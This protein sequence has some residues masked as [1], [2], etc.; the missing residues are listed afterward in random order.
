MGRRYNEDAVQKDIKLVPYKIIKSKNGDSWVVEVNSK[1][2]S[3]QEVSEQVLI[4]LK[5]DAE[6]YLGKP[7]KD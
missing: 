4:K 7:E 2:L 1:K 3:P 6:V 5:K